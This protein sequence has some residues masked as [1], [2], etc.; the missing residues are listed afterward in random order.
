MKKIFSIV[1]LL[2]IV[3][4]ASSAQHS[5]YYYQRATLFEK[6]PTNQNDIIFLGN[7]ITDGGEWTELLGNPNA[8]NRGISGDVTKGVID[9]LHTI[10]KG[11]PAKLFLLIGINDVSRG[12]S[13]DSIANNIKRIV[14]TVQTD[15]P[16]TKVYIQSILPVTPS[17]NMFH[18]H[19]SK[20]EVVKAVNSILQD[21]A[22]A[23]DI[24]YI[25]LYSRFV[26]P[27]TGEMDRR[28][29]NDGLHLLGAGYVLWAEII[30]PYID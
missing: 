13:A 17:F 10:T 4:F 22:V 9:R 27:N 3:V 29:T 20:L 30:K 7:S 5:T 25:D 28:Y 2:A 15:T 21:Y 19:T 14:S 26:D 1:A 18:G 12:L 24:T 8:R 6:L 11:K 23:Q 16:N